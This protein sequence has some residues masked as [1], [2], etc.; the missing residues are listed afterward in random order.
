LENKVVMR[1]ESELIA[2]LRE[3]KLKQ[4]M[5]R[6]EEGFETILEGLSMGFGLDILDANLADT[7]A[8]VARTYA[9]IFSGLRDTESQLDDVLMKA[10]PSESEGMILMR[11]IEVFSMCPHHFLPVEMKVHIAYIP[12]GGSEGRV[13]GLSKIARVAEILSKRPVLQEQFTS[14]VAKTFM[15]LPGCQGAAC[16]V[17]GKHFCMAIRGVKKPDAVTIT[18]S[19]QGIFETDDAARYEFLSLVRK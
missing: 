16:F 12:G 11:G 2:T 7:P 13:L 1:P 10:F 8:R 19:L 4:A 18:S 14:D 15:K 5:T 6:V 3:S 17:E 9:E